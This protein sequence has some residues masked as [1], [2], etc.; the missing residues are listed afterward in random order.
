MPRLLL[1]LLLMSTVSFAQEGIIVRQT[2]ETRVGKL[3]VQCGEENSEHELLLEGKSIYKNEGKNLDVVK[4]FHTRNGEVVLLRENFGGSGTVD[5]HFFIQLRKGAE[6]VITPL[7]ESQGGEISA[8]QQGDA[9]VVDLGFNEGKRETLTYQDGKQTIRREAPPP[10]QPADKKDCRYLYEDVYVRFIQNERCGS[11]LDSAG[12]M[13]ITRALHHL[14][15]DPRL[16][17]EA[18]T[19]LSH[20]S[21]NDR[22]PLSYTEFKKKICGG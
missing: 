2:V 20:Q 12:G 1:S 22:K 14:G 13:A 16:D 11:D 5:E 8:K 18:L 9:L 10:H 6:P 17:L 7:F 15:H 21:C 3:R 4:V 19:P